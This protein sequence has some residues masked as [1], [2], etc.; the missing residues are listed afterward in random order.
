MSVVINSYFILVISV[1]RLMRWVVGEIFLKKTASHELKISD[2]RANSLG[3]ECD[4]TE[5]RAANVLFSSPSVF[6]Q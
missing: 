6:L 4:W 3:R 2:A 5:E 1:G